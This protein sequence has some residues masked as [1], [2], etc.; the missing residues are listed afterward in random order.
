VRPPN[1][2]VDRTLGG[3]RDT[4]KLCRATT[5]AAVARSPYRRRLNPPSRLARRRRFRKSHDQRLEGGR[6]QEVLRGVVT[7]GVTKFELRPRGRRQTTRGGEKSRE[8]RSWR[9]KGRQA[10]FLIVVKAARARP[11]LGGHFT[12]TESTEKLAKNRPRELC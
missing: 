1:R 4:S 12:H 9:H 5:S 3:W 10:S 6:L 11:C 2:C 7:A 8:N